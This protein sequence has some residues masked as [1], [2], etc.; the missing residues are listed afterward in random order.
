MEE[1]KKDV[2]KSKRKK[3][4]IWI[5]II[6]LMLISIASVYFLTDKLYQKDTIDDDTSILFTKDTLPR[7]DASLATQ[8]LTDAFIK[9]FTGKTTDEVGITYSNTHPG[10]V[11]LINN[12]ADL[13]VVT[14]PS[15]EELILA[16]EKGIELETTKVVNEGF[17]FFV[18]KDNPVDSVTLDEVRK[19]YAGEITNWK[20]LGGNDKRIIAY[21][22]PV[23]SGSQTGLL[24]LVM[25]DKAVKIPT[26]T[27][28]IETMGGIIDIVS[29]YDNG[30]DAVGY[31][32]YYYANV[33]YKNDNL[34]YL[35]I[36]GVKPEY[37][38]IQNGTYPLLTAY[39]IVTRKGETNE[40]V[41]KLKDA[42]LS[43]RGQMVAKK[44]GY[45]PSN[46]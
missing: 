2:K 3:I 9:D 33:M 21:Q 36:N 18:N 29:D 35:G 15:K 14:E 39:Y 43:R 37:E 5:L 25:K 6:L 30:I 11:K 8:P 1:V 12:E 26:T 45:V 7:I 32:Y 41:L 24:S 4:L 16:K 28:Q 13:I 38:T 17:V 23:N 46:S 27:E 22:R 40:N 34:K 42:M 19:I 10:Y 20:E 31:S 44:A